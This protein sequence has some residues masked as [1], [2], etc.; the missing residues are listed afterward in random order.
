MMKRS[1]I[2][3]GLALFV[4]ACASNSKPVVYKHPE[5]RNIIML[6]G[7]TMQCEPLFRKAGYRKVDAGLDD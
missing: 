3:I 4:T 6:D 7:D 1:L 5:T 2:M